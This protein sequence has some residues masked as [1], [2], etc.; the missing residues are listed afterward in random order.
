M[1]EASQKLLDADDENL[2]F[3]EE[4]EREEKTIESS[5]KVL[6]VDDEIEIHHITKL[7]LK[8]FT[9]ENKL[10][11]FVSAYSGKEAK[12]IIK[13]NQD[14]ALILLDVVMETEEAGLE[15]VKYIRDILDN[16]IV[17]IILR[18]GQP[19]QVPEDVVIVSYD[20][21]DYKTKT[22]LTNKKLFTTVVTALRAFSSL[23]QIESSK[24]ELEKIAA[25]SARF[26]PREFLKFLKRES[27][28]DARLGD[29]VQAEMTIMFA[30]IRSFT[31]LSE[32]MSP[33]DN[34]DFINSYLTRVGPV[35]RQ[36]NGFIDKYLGDGIMALFPNRPEDAV[37]AAIE[38]QQQVKIYNKHRQNSGYQPISIGIGLHTGTLMLGTIGEAERMEST[39]I[40]DAVN[41][42]SRVEGLTKLYGVGIVA[43]VQ[44]LCRIDDPQHYKCRFLDRVQVKGKQ[45]PV[46]VFEIYDGDSDTMIE[47]KTQTQTYFEQ[48]IFFHYQQQFAQA[49][50]MFLRVLQVNKQ[51]KAAQFY[52]ER[53]DTLMKNGVI[54][55]VE[56]IEI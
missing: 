45:T 25:A 18:T 14:I 1:S 7:A 50:Q 3:I 54:L 56:G 31:S 17:R 8:D 23:N 52:A 48:G 21:N 2:I 16:Q 15:V 35:I 13:E 30:D 51:D 41:L 28:V 42:A 12:E 22:E 36:Y 29:S 34:F 47:L 37:Q 46:A 19:G 40:S 10:I 33:R 20:I 24:S 43:S 49:R 38:M 27:I 53:C 5:W 9:F 6:I 39:V 26:V 32:S 11:S 55:T 4:D 44:T